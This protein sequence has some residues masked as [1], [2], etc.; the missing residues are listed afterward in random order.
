MDAQVISANAAD[1]VDIKELG[2]ALLRVGSNLM[3]CGANTRRI[4]MTVE[5]ISGAFNCTTELLIT[6]RALMLTVSD[7][8]E[9][10]FH[11][12]LKRTS[13]HGVNFSVVSGISIMSWKVVQEGWNID[14]INTEL[15]RL[16]ELP[17]YPRLVILLMVGIADAAFC[18]LFGGGWEEMLVAFIATFAGLY[19]RQ[20]AVKRKFNPYLCIFFASFVS[21]LIAGLFVKFGGSVQEYALSASVLYLIPGVPLINSF[22]DLIHGNIMNGIVRSVNGLIIAFAIAFGL[23]LAIQIC[24]L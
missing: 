24:Q 8:N 20:E 1:K 19:V 14:Q 2:K 12:S 17:H 21:S 9:D 4:R 3:S 10:H 23:L 6:H 5:R 18:R 22:S 15:D 13:P 16:L 7:E 11:S